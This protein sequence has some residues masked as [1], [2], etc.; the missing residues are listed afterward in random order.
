MEPALSRRAF[1]LASGATASGVALEIA[2][3]AV[4]ATRAATPATTVHTVAR[5][6][7]AGGYRRLSD[8]PGWRRVTRTELAEAKKG[9]AGRRTVL[10]CF[11][12][13]TDLHITDVQSP[14]R[15]E[16][17][18]AADLG[19]W[20]PQEALTAVGAVSM[21]ERINALRYGPATRAPIGFVMTTGDN[22]D[23]NSH[24]E[25]EWF[26]TAMTGGRFTPDTGDP[27]AY[28]GAQNCG[29]GLYWQPESGLR[30]IDKRAGFPRLEGFLEAAIREVSSPGLAVPW[31]STV[32]NH[33]RLFGGAYREAGGFFADLATGSR[34]LFSLPASEAGAVYRALRGGD[35]AG[36]RFRAAWERHKGKARTVTADERRAPLSPRA[37]VAAHLDPAYTGPG[38]AGHGYTRDNLDSGRLDY[39]F[40]ISDGVV[41]ISLDTTDRGGDYR[42]SVGTRQLAW[43]KRTLKAHADDLVLVFSHHPSWAM[44]NLTP[45]PDRPRDRRHGGQELLAVLRGHRNVVAW[46]NGHSHRNKIVPHGGLWE[47]STASHVDYPQLARVVE[48]A[49][50]HDGTLSLFTTL[51]ESAAPHRTDFT[52]LS[53][54]GL[55]ALYRELSFNS[56]GLRS[57]LAGLP[58]DRN[59]ELLLRKR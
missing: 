22:T 35:P 45:S 52:D 37:Y 40:R 56:P 33:D 8:G 46:I 4:P 30:D 42:G 36:A 53:Q 6:S 17:L 38:P 16:F 54:R 29:L 15:Y 39:S 11:V 50:N 7:G 32:G 55:A 1:L 14:Q 24:I 47:I 48:L 58:G 28:E 18:R 27:G 51:V 20:R 19:F 25:M 31:Y 13:L 12:Q 9:R 44:T 23:N 5:P 41:G 49:D 3:S 43:L 10:A 2:L 59:T 26:L 34:K 57:G 21:I